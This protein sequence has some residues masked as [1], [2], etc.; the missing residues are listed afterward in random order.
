[1]YFHIFKI[2][3]IA[4]VKTPVVFLFIFA[5]MYRSCSEILKGS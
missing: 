1:M 4:Y 2:K 5:Y 3:D